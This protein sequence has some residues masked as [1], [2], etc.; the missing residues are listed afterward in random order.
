MKKFFMGTVFGFFLA[1]AVPAAAFASPAASTHVHGFVSTLGPHGNVVGADVEAACNGHVAATATDENGA[2]EVQF[3]Y[4]D[5]PVGSPVTVVASKTAAELSGRNAGAVAANNGDGDAEIFVFMASDLRIKGEVFDAQ[6]H[7]APGAQVKVTCDGHTV[8]TTADSNGH[9]QV[10]FRAADCAR[11]GPW[12][13]V[14]A[15]QGGF[16]GTVS[17]PVKDSGNGV[18]TV[19]KIQLTDPV[20]VPEMGGFAAA[21]ALAIASGALLLLRRRA[22]RFSLR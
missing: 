19:P 14:T 3:A 6:N 8:P 12:L 18:V 17:T 16:S 11:G 1:I 21:S 2:Y 13:E 10:M 5:C 20:T 4:A 7:L 9:Y 15:V 22:Q